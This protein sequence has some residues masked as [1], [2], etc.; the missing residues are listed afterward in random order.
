MLALAAFIEAFWS[1]SRN[2]EDWVK[3]AVG[4][5]LWVSVAYYFIFVGRRAT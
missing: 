1:S 2:I 4:A 3:Y 5:I